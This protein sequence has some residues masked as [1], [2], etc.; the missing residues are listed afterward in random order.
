MDFIMK[1]LLILLLTVFVVGCA[2]L[3]ED[4]CYTADWYEI[5]YSDGV[6]G[7]PHS[8]VEKH[9]KACSKHGVRANFDEWQ[10][11]HQ[12]GLKRYCTA[13]KGYEEGLNNRTYHGVCE[14]RP[15]DQFLQAYEQGQ[16]LY[17]Q[18]T[19]VSDL[20][21]DIEQTSE[22]IVGLEDEWNAIRS[23]LLNDDLTAAER[24]ELIN[25]LERNKE[26][27][28]T[29]RI[30]RDRL[31]DDLYRAQYDLDGLERMNNRYY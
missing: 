28:E 5:G 25:Q 31:D 3:N 6:K 13:Q 2:T 20:Q 21:R 11:G 4:E 9:R 22:E 16:K 17:Q 30:R 19:L 14:G 10:S 8:Y 1:F 29:L 18:R 24:A 15:A 26:H 23:Q 27:S 7:Q 12:A